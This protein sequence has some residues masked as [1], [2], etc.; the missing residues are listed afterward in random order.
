[1][2][3][4]APVAAAAWRD[5]CERARSEGVDCTVVAALR[6]IGTARPMAWSV[7][8]VALP[9]CFELRTVCELGAN[10]EVLYLLLVYGVV[11]LPLAAAWARAGERRTRRDL[12]RLADDFREALTSRCARP[13]RGGHSRP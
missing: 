7:D 10:S 5:A 6:A 8:V 9:D 4:A 11:T 12:D 2:S 13:Y 1:M 3:G